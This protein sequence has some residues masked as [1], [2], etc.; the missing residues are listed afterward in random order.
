MFWGCFTYDK[1]GPC[2]IWTPE[3]KQEKAEAQKAID[4]MNKELEPIRKEEWELENGIRR[5]QLRGNRGVKPTW[6]F[7]SKTRKLTRREGAGID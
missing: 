1:K 2:Y 5:L 7:N 4:T 6:K 3:T